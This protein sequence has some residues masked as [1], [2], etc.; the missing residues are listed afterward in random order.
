M[1]TIIPAVIFLVTVFSCKNSADSK[2]IAENENEKK[3]ES[4]VM[5]EESEFVVDAVDANM[6]EVQLGE[7]ALKNALSPEVKKLA[8][9]MIDDHGKAEKELYDIAKTK[10]IT[11]PPVLSNKSQRKYDEL[12]KKTGYD[13]DR[14]YSEQMVKDHKD[15]IELF[16]KENDKGRDAEIKAWAAAKLSTL[17]E[18]LHM[19]ETTDIDVKNKEG[20]K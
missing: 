6:L 2:K 13:F 9:R 3:F 17:Q 15:A 5:D 16:Q 4:T 10:N 20:K 7:M 12:V 1:R 11:I 19:A 18:H 8:Q 14:A